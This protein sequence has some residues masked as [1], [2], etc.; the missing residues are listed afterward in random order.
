MTSK[1]WL[2]FRCVMLVQ[3]IEHVP[4]AINKM[5][6]VAVSVMANCICTTIAYVHYNK[7][8]CIAAK[9]ICKMNLNMTCIYTEYQFSQLTSGGFRGRARH[10]PV[11]K[12]SSLWSNDRVER[13]SLV[14]GRPTS[15]NRRYSDTHT[16]SGTYLGK[17]GV[18][19]HTGEK[20]WR[21]AK[22]YK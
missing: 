12:L 11:Y 17:S 5:F 2:L 3:H 19:A 6:S 10:P 8:K 4:I 7:T 13:S 21:D 15:Q 20:N 9:Y 18:C 1:R 14:P 16:H 22:C